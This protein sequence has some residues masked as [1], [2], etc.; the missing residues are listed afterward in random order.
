MYE[1][2]VLMLRTTGDEV[3]GAY[4]SAHWNTRNQLLEDGS[5]QT[6]FGTGET[7]AGAGEGE[8]G[9]EGWQRIARVKHNSESM[10]HATVTGR[11]EACRDGTIYGDRRDRGVKIY[12]I[13]K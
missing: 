8:K 5:R 2:T 12:R 9:V 13:K 6:Y 4:C 7:A 1:P 11:E 3:F 10:R